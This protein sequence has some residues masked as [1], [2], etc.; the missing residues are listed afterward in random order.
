MVALKTWVNG[1]RVDAD[2]LNQNF[3][4]ISEMVSFQDSLNAGETIDGLTT[5]VP[6]YV[7]SDGELYACDANDTAKLNFAGFV[8][9]ASSDG[10]PIDFYGDGIISGFTGLTQGARYYV[11]DSV[12][13]IGTTPGTYII[14]V[15]IAVSATKLLIQKGSRRAHGNVGFSDGGLSGATQDTAFTIGF[16]PSRIR[17]SGNEGSGNI[18]GFSYS[19]GTWINGTYQS[20]WKWCNAG[21]SADGIDTG[22]ILKVYNGSGSFLWTLTITSITATGFTVHAVQEHDSPGAVEAIW[23]AESDI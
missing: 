11:Q 3:E 17:M 1:E 9:S 7:G 18:A 20:Y 8:T 13:T 21:A 5:P 22:A 4:T 15:G 12:G 23:E 10:N 16:R 2:D 6:V 19:V 14:F